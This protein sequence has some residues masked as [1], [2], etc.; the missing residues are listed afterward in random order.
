MTNLADGPNKEAVEHAPALS[1]TDSLA[2][3]DL[4]EWT[5]RGPQTTEWL[6]QQVEDGRVDGVSLGGLDG[7]RSDDGSTPFEDGAAG[8]LNPGPDDVGPSQEH[9][10]F[11]TSP[12]DSQPTTPPKGP[13]GATK[14]AAAVA[15]AADTA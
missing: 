5:I 2:E 11:D 9:E 1:S 3:E 4:A 12:D 10:V 15:K 7:E 6:C 13:K 8:Q 14:V